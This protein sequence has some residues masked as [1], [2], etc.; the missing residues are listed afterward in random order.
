M[1][2][3]GDPSFAPIFKR[4]RELWLEELEQKP[5]PTSL[6]VVS[7]D[8]VIVIVGPTGS[9]K[10]SASI[11][12]AKE[13]ERRRLGGFS[14][15][16]IISA[17]SRAIYKGMDIG[18]AK[19]TRSEQGQ[20]KHWGIDLVEPGERFTVFDWKKYAEVKIEE[21]FGRGN[22]PIIVGG[23]G[24][25]VDALIYDY[26]FSRGDIEQKNCSNKERSGKGFERDEKVRKNEQI[27]YPDRQK[28]C[29][30]YKIFG[31]KVKPEILKERLEKRANKLFTQELYDETRKLVEKYGWGSQAMKSN[32]YQFAWRYMNG[33]ISR[34]E[35]IR[36]NVFD[37]YHLAKRQMT[38]FKRNENILWLPLEKV[39]QSVLK[40]IQD[41]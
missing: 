32:I 22:L 11:E 18:T 5:K 27:L 33:E 15:V 38:W 4:Q 13:I 26:Q 28:M 17:D 30:R 12:I 23:T 2:Y 40:C 34:E 16:E 6:L 21:I 35:A 10:T 36:L 20:V 25:Y 41:E 9:G 8:K 7:E 29:S 24:L 37:D 3:G 14:R 39:K 1:T 31:V 19:P